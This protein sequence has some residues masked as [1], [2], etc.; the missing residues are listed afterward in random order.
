MDSRPAKAPGH[1]PGLGTLLTAI[2]A[3]VLV[4]FPPV[5]ELWHTLNHLLSGDLAAIRPLPAVGAA[6]GLAAVLYGLARTLAR[7][8]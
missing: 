5:Y 1:A 6:L 4:G 3:F 8:S 2:T 7:W